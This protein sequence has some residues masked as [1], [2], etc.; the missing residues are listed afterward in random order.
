[1]RDARAAITKLAPGGAGCR[2]SLDLRAALI[3]LDASLERALG[4]SSD[5][6]GAGPDQLE[7]FARLALVEEAAAADGSDAVAAVRTIVAPLGR[8]ARGRAR[9]FR[10]KRT[11]RDPSS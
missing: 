4:D 10:S 6:L 5:N 11:R 3:N 9:P 2:L 1:M 8:R 7:V